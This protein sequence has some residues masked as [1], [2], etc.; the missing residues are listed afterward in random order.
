VWDPK[1]HFFNGIAFAIGF[2]FGHEGRGYERKSWDEDNFDG[3]TTIKT[4]TLV[5]EV[6][7]PAS[8]TYV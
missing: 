8:G 3:D 7:T 2:F 4:P 1:S 6:K 5:L